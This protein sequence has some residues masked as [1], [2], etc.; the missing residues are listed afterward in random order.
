[1]SRIAPPLP[2]TLS[3]AILSVAVI[4]G[5]CTDDKEKPDGQVF[6]AVLSDGV[7]TLDPAISYDTVS[8]TPVYNIYET[9]YQYSY[10][11]N[12]YELEPLL[13]A[14]MPEV[15]KDGLTVTIPIRTDAKFADDPAFKATEGEGRKLKAQDF[16]YGFKRL[17]LSSIQSPGFWIFEGKVKGIDEFKK[18]INAA[19]KEKRMEMLRSE[20]VEGLKA[21]DDHTLQ[22]KLTRRY[23]QL[24][25]VL[26]MSFTAPV[27]WEASE[28]YADESGAMHHQPVGTGPFMLE[29]WDRGHRMV[30]VRN[31]DYHADSYPKHGAAEFKKQGLLADSGKPLPFLERVELEVIKESQPSWL[32]FMQGEVEVMGIPKDNFGSAMEDQMTLSEDM[33]KKGIKLSIE[34]GNVFYWVAFNM[35]DP[36]VGKN[37]KLRQAISSAIDRERFIELFTNNRG[38]KATTV[39]PPGIAGRPD[40]S[41][42]KYDFDLERA[43]KLLADAG[44][45]EGKGLD[46]IKFDMR[47]QSSVSRQMGEFFT[48]QL[49]EVGIQ[50]KV[51]MNT[52]PAFLEKAKQGNL[53]V[54]MGG[55]ALDYPDAENAYQLLYGPN[56]APGPNDSNY[57]NPKMNKLYEKMARMRPSPERSKVI[58]QMD[59]IL[60]EE[61]PWALLYYRQSY[62]L[63]QPWLENYRGTDMIRNTFKYY[64]I[65]NDRR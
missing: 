54:S 43:K 33:R 1:M 35:L 7:K 29:K 8:A 63:Y 18:K 42:L 10:L 45:P 32:K 52:F 6:H 61:A 2:R 11:S 58:A 57:D 41:K 25:Y 55:W 59:A 27:A 48:K 4:L 14:D 12:P 23:P 28:A 62:R 39:L 30:L 22:I 47:G 26:A 44:Y 49:A 46:P 3:A 16:I 53:Q 51:I 37:K 17:V 9:L 64:R 50:L 36:V 65:N 15:S 5:G 60:Q 31:P 56:K 13:A 34:S 40:N 38:K 21:L 20:P 24:L 19:P